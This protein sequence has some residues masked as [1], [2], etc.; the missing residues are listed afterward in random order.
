MEPKAQMVVSGAN[1]ARS[2]VWEDHITS[3]SHEIRFQA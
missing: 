3:N 1:R 2:V